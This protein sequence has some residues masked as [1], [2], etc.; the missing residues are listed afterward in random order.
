MRILFLAPKY[1]NLYKPI[2]DELINKGHDVLYLEDKKLQCDIYTR[3]HKI[4]LLYIMHKVQVNIFNE[5]KR[6]WLNKINQIPALNSEFDIFFCINGVSFHPYLL[7]VLKKNNPNIKTVIYI[8][9][10]NKYYDY[11]RNIKYFDYKFSFD[12]ADSLM[13][14]DVEF[15][16]FYWTPY[17]VKEN[18]NKYDISLI[19]SDHDGRLHF[20]NGISQYLFDNNVSFYFKI[21]KKKPDIVYNK[22]KNIVEFGRIKKRLEKV[23]DEWKKASKSKFFSE[24]ILSIDAV[25]RIMSQ[26]NC[27]LD[28]DRETQTGTTPRLIWALAQGKKVITTNKN[29]K[30]MPFFNPQQI[31]IIDRNNPQIDINFVKSNNK[32]NVS[33]LIIDLRID[34]WINR[35]L[36]SK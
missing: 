26:S 20:I 23:Y 31:V 18:D 17:D 25:N 8:W 14:Y 12:I 6:Y 35:I 32:F 15:I 13:H 5:Y 19:G 16:P 36:F 2:L 1:L 30:L 7:D 3:E 21:Y 9:D 34:N 24:E 28:T 11:F 29:I 22:L 33:P 4:N 10:T 27:I